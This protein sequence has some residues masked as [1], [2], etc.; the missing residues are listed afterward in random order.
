MYARGL[1]LALM[2]ALACKSDPSPPPA[3]T[4][5]TDKPQAE[6]S[7]KGEEPTP[8]EAGEADAE[9]ERTH[10]VVFGDR[11][12]QGYLLLIEP[13]K[14]SAAPTRE[15]L[16]AL[17]RREFGK[18]AE[19]GE[20]ALLRQLIATEPHDT[21][22]DPAKLDFDDPE[23]LVQA[24]ENSET[25][26]RG[27]LLGL[28]IKLFDRNRDPGVIPAEALAD[29]IATRDLSEAERTS[30]EGRS[31]ILLLR[32][33]YRNQFDVR[34]LRLLQG[35]VR[36][37]AKKHD[38][39][40]FD[41]DTLETR[42]EAK[43][44]ERRLTANLANVVDQLAVIPFKDPER[45]GKARLSTRGMRRFGLPDLE[46]TGLPPEPQTL[47][48]ATDLLAGLARVLIKEG[49]VDQLGIAIEAPEIIEVT[50]REVDAAY[51]DIGERLPPRCQGCPERT[52]IHLV[53]R[54]ER[55]TDTRDHMTVGV[56]APRSES[57]AADFDQSK[58]VEKAIADLF[59]G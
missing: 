48:R 23:A 43:F 9:S 10:R 47:Q 36:L 31:K 50:R 40:V 39:L 53:R 11:T 41:P 55:D 27:D 45:P 46:L 18:A 30:I 33:D 6:S 8:A 35:L 15:E 54:P 49:E 2:I 3:P 44:T 14:L 29:P 25:D 1:P 32:A 28:H 52:S 13:S 57:D 51:A 19:E 17:V 38:A 56:T 59:G 21:Q 26:R 37:V 34:G 20:L 5:T 58:W 42:G 4:Q 7:P 24:V 16:D 12:S 22:L